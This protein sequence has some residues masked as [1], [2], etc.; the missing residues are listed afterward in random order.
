M[1]YMAIASVTVLVVHLNVEPS[2]MLVITV[3]TATR[4]KM[5]VS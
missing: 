2:L 5:A 3:G 1:I 4:I